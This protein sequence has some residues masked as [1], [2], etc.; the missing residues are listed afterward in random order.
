MQFFDPDE[1]ISNMS[2]N[3]PHWRQKNTI[4]F[5][6]FRLADSL[7]QKKLDLWTQERTEWNRTHPEPHTEQT[8]RE[9]SRLFPERF[10]KWLDAG[11]GECILANKEVKLL[12][13]NALRHFNGV[14]FDLYESTVMPNHLLTLVRPYSDYDLSKILHSWKSFTSHEIN[15]MR[16]KKA[17]IWQKESFD[18]IVRSQDQLEK[19]CQYIRD[20]PKRARGGTPRLP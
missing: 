4:Y 19:I 16:V 7:P 13:E 3:L 18:H 12:V 14:Y 5:A 9:Y 6:T 15:K 10:H 17:R 11:Y 8:K 20:N 2:G 1:P